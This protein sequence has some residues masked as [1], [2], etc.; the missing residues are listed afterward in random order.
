MFYE[1]VMLAGVNDGEE[2]AHQLGQ[3]LQVG[4]GGKGLQADGLRQSGG[5]AVCC[6]LW[7]RRGTSLWV[8]CLG[9]GW[10][11]YRKRRACMVFR[12]RCSGTVVHVLVPP[13]GTV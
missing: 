11:G 1:Y 5:G 8:T 10:A 4:A 3:L 2:Q 9:L 12:G 6:W 13:A 7:G